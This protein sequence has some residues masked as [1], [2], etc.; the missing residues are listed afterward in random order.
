MF[1]PTYWPRFSATWPLSS[2]EIQPYSLAVGPPPITAEPFTASKGTHVRG[3]LAEIARYGTLLGS[4][5]EIDN[6]EEP[7]D[8][9]WHGTLLAAHEPTGDTQEADENA[10]ED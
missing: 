8:I 9:A 1:T 5:E 4:H 3:E 10:D 6:T 2:R 7:D